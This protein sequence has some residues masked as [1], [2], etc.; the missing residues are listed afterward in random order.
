MNLYG[1]PTCTSAMKMT[2]KI[3]L[4]TGHYGLPVIWFVFF[5]LMI[6]NWLKDPYDPDLLHPHGHNGKNALI[7]GAGLS[8]FELALFYLLLRPWSFNQSIYRLLTAFLVFLPWN[9]F[10][11]IMCFHAGGII[12]LHFY[13]VS[14]LSFTLLFLM[15]LHFAVK[16]IRKLK[17]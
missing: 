4:L 5:V 6:A 8:V 16:I 10:S 1:A 11:L 13:F 7:I 2:K 3:N 15:I 17:R 12:I 9:Y 14:F